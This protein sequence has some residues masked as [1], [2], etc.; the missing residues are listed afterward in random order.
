MENQVEISLNALYQT[1]KAML[2]LPHIVQR[3]LTIHEGR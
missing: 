1:R 2:N 3:F